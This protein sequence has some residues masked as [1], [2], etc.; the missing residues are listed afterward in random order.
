M[1]IKPRFYNEPK[2][3]RTLIHQ[4]ALIQKLQKS[5]NNRMKKE[6]FWM[7]EINTIDGAYVNINCK[8]CGSCIQ[9]KFKEWQNGKYERICKGCKGKQLNQEIT[10]IYNKVQPV[11]PKGYVIH[12]RGFEHQLIIRKK[13]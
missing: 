5:L 9:I 13:E 12:Q 10:D 7:D 3:K 1:T 8:M 11:L 6:K 2:A 4:N